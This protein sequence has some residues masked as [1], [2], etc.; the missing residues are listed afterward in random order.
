MKK[1]RCWRRTDAKERQEE[2]LKRTELRLRLASVML[3]LQLGWGWP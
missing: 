2:R 3:H 1:Q